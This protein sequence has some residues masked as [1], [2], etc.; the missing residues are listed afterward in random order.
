VDA[1]WGEFALMPPTWACA[2]KK[3]KPIKRAVRMLTF[4]FI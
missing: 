3:A 2:G 4:N 1:N